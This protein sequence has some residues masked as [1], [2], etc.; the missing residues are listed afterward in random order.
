MT[1]IHFKGNNLASE[2]KHGSGFKIKPVTDMMKLLSNNSEF[3]GNMCLELRQLP[4]PMVII[5]PE[6]R[7]VWL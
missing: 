1:V 7:N 4:N 6:T 2:S 5:A 3:F